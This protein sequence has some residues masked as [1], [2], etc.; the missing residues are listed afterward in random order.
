MHRNHSVL[1]A[2][3]TFLSLDPNPRDEANLGAG[4]CADRPINLIE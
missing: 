2:A 4:A 1:A 3:A